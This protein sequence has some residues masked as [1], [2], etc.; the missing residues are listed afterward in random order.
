MAG[1]QSHPCTHSEIM[2]AAVA[3]VLTLTQESDPAVMP[4]R[5]LSIRKGVFTTPCTSK[6]L[7]SNKD[8]T[9]TY[10]LSRKSLIIA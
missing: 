9:F 4:M 2:D 1:S 3:T 10:K 6:S 7:P 8:E 5:C